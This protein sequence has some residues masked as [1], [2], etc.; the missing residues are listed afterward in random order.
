LPLGHLVADLPPETL[1]LDADHLRVLA[2]RE[3]HLA[4]KLL[5]LARTLD[6]VADLKELH[7]HMKQGRG[8]KSLFTTS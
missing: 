7:Q 8:I 6:N 5:A 4:E 1:R 3:P 2:K